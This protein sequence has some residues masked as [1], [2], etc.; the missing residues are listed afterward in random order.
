MKEQAAYLG[1]RT[2]NLVEGKVSKTGP[3]EP[4]F[5][6]TDDKRKTPDELS[7]DFDIKSSPINYF[8]YRLFTISYKASDFYPVRFYVDEELINDIN[9][10]IQVK[11]RN[12]LVAKNEKEFI[13]I[14]KDIFNSKKVK[15][16]VKS[17]LDLLS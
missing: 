17:I 7:F 15:I 9:K 12:F 3:I 16:I 10:Y 13:E 11:N 4:S 1:K 6:F 2:K 8:G 5:E 14:L